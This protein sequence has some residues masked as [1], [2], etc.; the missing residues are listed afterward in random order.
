MKNYLDVLNQLKIFGLQLNALIVDGRVHRVRA[1]KQKEKSGWYLLHE[2]QLD[3]GSS[4]IVG[5]YGEWFGSESNTQKIQL[6]KKEFSREQIDAIKKRH[7]D[8][9][10]RI[11]AENKARHERCAQTAEY[12]WKK[13]S[14][15]GSCDYLQKKG[16]GAHGVKFSEKSSLIIPVSNT[17]GHILG[18]QI[19]L[20]SKISKERIDKL[21]RNKEF[22]PSGMAKKGNFH[23]IGSPNELILVAEGYAT[24]ATLHEATKLPVAVAF[25]A[26]N[27]EPVIASLKKHYRNMKFLICADNDSLATCQHCHEKIDLTQNQTTCPNCNKPHGK[28]NTGIER[29][30]LAAVTHACAVVYPQ[31]SDNAERFFAYQQ[32]KGK[33]TDFNDLM[34]IESLTSVR[35]QIE[36]ALIE[37]GWL[38]KSGR[39]RAEG[40][41][42]VIGLPQLISTVNDILENYTLVSGMDS[43][44]FDHRFRRLI[45]IK[46]IQNLCRS[47]DTVGR[48]KERKDRKTVLP[49]NVG[50]D[51]AGTDKKILCNLW[52]GFEMMPIQGECENILGLLKYMCLEDPI[53]YDW[54]LKWLAYPLQNAGA[55]MKSALV[56]HGAQGTGKNLFFE[57]VMKIYGQYGRI[58]TQDAI[59]DKFND[60]ASKK[61]FLIADEVVA[62]ADLYHI[63]NKLKSFIT[64][65]EI[66]INPKNMSSYTEQNHVNMVFLSNE[67]MPVVLEEDDRRHGVIWTP[68]KLDAEFYE[69][70]ALEVRNGGIEALYHYLMMLD[71]GNFSEH[72]K[73][74]MTKAKQDLIHLSKDST[75]RFFEDWVTG[76]LGEA[77][78]QPTLSDDIYE[79]YKTWCLL[80]G[81]RAAPKFRFIDFLIKRCGVSK[82]RK[83]YSINMSV[84]PNPKTFLIP[85]ESVQR[86][87]A[88]SETMWLGECV[89]NM[90]LAIKSFRGGNYE[91]N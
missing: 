32:N 86:N 78:A 88:Q 18:L 64:S 17:K 38:S 27:I 31:F 51:P 21:G 82:E 5:T 45:S 87:P 29:A 1:N 8:D 26:N 60:W 85:K 42:D 19:I 46:E 67:R 90:K 43:V 24:A 48:W 39:P 10:K 37:K 11:E 66:R 35:V 12:A 4:V 9:K 77:I 3:D 71:L 56:I 58:I 33:Q 54:M 6:D 30:N 80:E 15:S 20:D 22:Y 49:E 53:M 74:P 23:L 72:S 13:M 55:K 79:L 73:P 34:H 63:K 84:T 50:F 89:K 47:R 81:V 14:V 70:V 59:E 16:I 2:M 75:Q 61:L 91:N 62:R 68:V 7:A 25:D 65:D 83:R 40:G 52:G 44:M 57:C 69:T 28:K 36:N 76:E 41:G